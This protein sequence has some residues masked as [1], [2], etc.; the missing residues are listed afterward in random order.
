MNLLFFKFLFL[1]VM[2]MAILFIAD[3]LFNK[4]KKKK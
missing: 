4:T 2:V 3:N 1:V